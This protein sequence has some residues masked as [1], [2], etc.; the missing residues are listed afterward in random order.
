V[1]S[2]IFKPVPV[3]QAQLTSHSRLNIGHHN[4]EDR[5]PQRRH[6]NPTRSDPVQQQRA[7]GKA[8]SPSMTFPASALIMLS[9]L[10]PRKSPSSSDSAWQASRPGSP[11][12]ESDITS[13]SRLSMLGRCSVRGCLRGG[14][15]EAG[16]E[17]S[18]VH[19]GEIVRTTELDVE[20]H[21]HCLQ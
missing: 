5:S 15:T 19:G 14:H 11:R 1:S 4:V 6:P 3:P 21:G 16:M 12:S 10:M 2:Q 18:P 13:T 7:S 9:R 20:H 8:I 17:S